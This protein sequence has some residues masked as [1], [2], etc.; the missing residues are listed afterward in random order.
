MQKYGTPH[1][2]IN[3]QDFQVC[4]SCKLQ[5]QVIEFEGRDNGRRGLKWDQDQ[6]LVLVGG[7]SV[8]W[9]AGTLT[10]QD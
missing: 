8:P 3:L 6:D 9:V 1:V 10:F 2:E 5:I 7:V 4:K